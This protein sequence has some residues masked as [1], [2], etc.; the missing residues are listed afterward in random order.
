MAMK[1]KQLLRKGIALCC[2]FAAIDS[3]QGY[4]VTN[5]PGY[6]VLSSSPG[7]GSQPQA[8]VAADVN[9]D[10]KVD[11]IA[12]NYGNGFGNSTLS[13]L[14]NNGTGGFVLASSPGTGVSPEALTAADVNGDGKVDLICANYS[15]WTL[16]VLTNNGHGGF[17]LAST[18]N[19]G[20]GPE[21]VTAADVNGDGKVDLICANYGDNTLSVF[22]NSGNG[23]FVLASSPG[24]GTGPR[25]VIA[26]TNIYGKMNLVSANYGNNTLTVLTNNGSGGFSIGSS[27]GVGVHPTM[28]IAADVN[29]DGRMDLI[30]A[31][32]GSSTLTV[33]TNN[34]SDGFST[35]TSPGAGSN[36][37]SV[38]AADVNG[39]GKIDLIAAN[40]TGS[41]TLTV[42]TND[43]SGGFVIDVSPSVGSA[44][45][46][47]TAADV[48][49]DGR[50]DLISANDGSGTLSI[51]TN[52]PVITYPL[53][54][55][56]FSPAS[57]GV[58]ASVT[59]NG[60]NLSLVTGVLFNGQSVTF[61]TNS[62]SQITATVPSCATSG[63][64][65]VNNASGSF[66]TTTNFTFLRQPI[67][68]TTTDESSLNYALCNGSTVTL[69]VDGT[70]GITSTKVIS[71]DVTLDGTGHSL[72]IN[73]SNSVAMFTVNPGVH[74]TLKNLKIANGQAISAGAGI[75]NNGGYVTVQN[76]TFSNN[77]AIGAAGVT[78][79]NTSGSTGAGG[80]ICNINGGTVIITGSTFIS[81]S[82]TG[83]TGS[84]GYQGAGQY[85]AGG[86]GGNGGSGIGGALCNAG[87]GNMLITNCTFFGNISA[88]GNGGTGGQGYNGYSY[89]YV[90]GSY[91]CGFGNTCYT[92][93]TGYVYGGPG[94]QG[95]SGG[96]GYGGNL[97]NSLGNVTLVN[98]TFANGSATGGA[99]GVG[100][101]AGNLGSGSYG[102]GS[103]GGGAGGNVGLGFGQFILLNS[104]V[105]N[106]VQGGNYWGGTITDGGNNLSSDATLVFT[107]TGSFTNTN[108]NLGSLTNNGGPTWTMALLPG[109]PAIDKGQ[110]IPGLTTDQRGLPRPSGYAFDIGAYEL[111]VVG[112]DAGLRAFDG[113]AIIKLAVEGPGSTNS[114]LRFSKNG[115]NYGILL[116]ATNSANASKFRIQTSSGTKAFMKLP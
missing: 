55:T 1:L 111:Q 91:P 43:G 6:F 40:N 44:S 37:Y 105:A 13:V 36:P 113:T 115:T 8:V 58:G 88:G 28:V 65:T 59:I 14:T 61:S 5:Y 110:T 77:A 7:V 2:L 54:I 89:Q 33:L 49:G 71:A 45:A 69:A 79:G 52:A 107:N 64:I 15:D 18:P 66:T 24:V 96:N 12:V 68:V 20:N 26:F 84:V 3:A 106:P 92:Y 83:G 104:I 16:T 87:S 10:G 22:T 93:C 38:A 25:S 11:L 4:S 90:C 97:Y 81:N 67:T 17:V 60:F 103:A 30:C 109:S 94:G 31:N 56:G 76:C 102:L 75:Y 51:L 29:K 9:G 98:V 21:S 100:G 57:A 74:L 63:P 27:P 62:D 32:S 108:P 50:V 86:T 80:A 35:A 41:G 42:L 53:Q 39:D 19:T 47:L 116:T 78:S 85:G 23:G 82:V 73:G 114:A 46:S 34:G 70:I 72:M 101:S 99:A 112:I 48:N 95:G